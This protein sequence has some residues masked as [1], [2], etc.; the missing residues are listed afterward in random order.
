MMQIYLILIKTNIFSNIYLS[1]Q[2]Y[3][4]MEAIK[5]HGGKRS[6][7]GRK[8]IT[9]KKKPVTIYSKESEINLLGGMDEA[10]L[11]LSN[12]ITRKIKY[13]KK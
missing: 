9:D 8:P 12:T 6:N 2:K 13:L 7:A 11:L 5:T 1:S 4:N 10:K 3:L